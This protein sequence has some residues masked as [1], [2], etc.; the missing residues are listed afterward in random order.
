M[1]AVVD[2]RRDNLS[3]VAYD[4]I[5]TMI[6]QKDLTPGQFIN[7]AQLQALL[8]LGRTPVREAVLALAQDKLVHIHPRKGIE[9]SRPTLK[10]IHDIFEIRSLLEPL[11]LHQCFHQVDLQW[12]VDMRTLLL[13]HQDDEAGNAG[14]T[15]APLIELDNEFH[16]KLVDTLHNQYASQL[17]RSLTEYLNLIRITAWRPSR[18]QVSNREHI[19]ILNA[20]LER[21]PED[22][23][24]LLS[25]HIQL[26]YQE[27][28]NTMIHCSF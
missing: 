16:L 26:S 12:A 13:Q 19:D 2:K 6:L 1:A 22:A 14:Q 8:G 17:M 4:Q 24:R 20:I 23:C 3:Q 5:K 18:Y 9:I 28:I 27:A 21:R 15:A 10:D 11:I 7:E 25:E